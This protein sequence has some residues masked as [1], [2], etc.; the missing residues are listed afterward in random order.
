MAEKTNS[1]QNL[2]YQVAEIK[3]AMSDLQREIRGLSEEGVEVVKIFEKVGQAV[4]GNVAETERVTAE[5]Q[6]S[7]Q[8]IIDFIAQKEKEGT[9]D[10][11]LRSGQASALEALIGLENKLNRSKQGVLRT[12]SE[13]AKEENRKRKL[14]QQ[15]AEEKFNADQN[16][17]AAIQE[18]SAGEKEI[19]RILR[20]KAAQ[21]ADINEEVYKR[22]QAERDAVA[23]EKESAQLKKQSLKEQKEL[24]QFMLEQ[25]LRRQGEKYDEEERLEQ[26]AL[27]R[28]K[29]AIAEQARLEKQEALAA[30]ENAQKEKAADDK[31]NLAKIRNSKLSVNRRAKLENDYWTDLQSNYSEDSAEYKELEV[32][33]LAA[34]KKYERERASV[35]KK[36]RGS[37]IK[38]TKEEQKGFFSQFKDGL[39]SKG[40]G[41]S[42]GRLAGLGGIVQAARKIFQG[43][44]KA[45]VG[46]F[47]ASVDFE[48]QLAQLQAVTGINNK[49]LARLEKNVLSVAGSTKFTSEEIVQL[50]TELG[51]LGFSVSEIEAATLAVAR[52]AQALGEKVGP[53]AQRI[54]QILNQFNLAAAETSRVSD[55]LVSVINSSALSFEGFSTALQYI[56]PLGAEVGTTFEETSVAMALLADNGFTASRIGTGLRGILTE[57]SKTGKDLNTVI[58]DL[59]KEE[60]TLAEAVDL[61]GKRNAAQLIT[62]VRTAKA[63]QEV[64][65]S[66]SDLTNEYF[67]TGSA[68]IAASQQVDT[69]QGNLDLLKSAVN[70]VQIAF[71]NF[72]KTSK[73]LKLAL[74]FIDEEGYNAAL[75]AEAIASADPV[76]FSKGMQEA[77]EAV[78]E[79]KGNLAETADVEK[80]AAEQAAKLLK[81]AILEPQQAILD[82]AA[83]RLELLE[84]ERDNLVDVE[85]IKA[86]AAGD[87]DRVAKLEAKRSADNLTAEAKSGYALRDV[88]KFNIA[89]AE[90]GREINEKRLVIS[91]RI[92]KA[93]E[94]QI[95]AQKIINIATSDEVKAQE[96]ALALLIMEAG[97]NEALENE[98]KKVSQEREADLKRLQN[99]RDKDLDSLKKANDFNVDV[100]S[101]YA[102]VEAKIN[103]L[104][105]KQK[106][107]K[108]EGQELEG[109]EL[110]LFNAKL[111]QYKQE[112]NSLA[113]LIVQKGDLE[114]LAQK[115]FEKEFKQLANRITARKQEL[116]DKQALLDIE[117]K[118]QE[119][120]SKNARTEEERRE[121]TEALT[122]LNKERTQNEVDAFNELNDITDEYG[123]LIKTIGVEIGRAQ[124]DGRFI[125]KAEER[126]KSFRLSFKG[127]DLDFGDLAKQ[128]DGLAKGLANTYKDTLD[129]GLELSDSEKADVANKAAALAKSFLQQTT[130]VEFPEVF[131]PE[132]FDELKER[133]QAQLDSVL[134]PD[135]DKDR[136]EQIKKVLG[137]VL[138]ELADAAKEYNDTAL[139]NT[140]GR[141]DAELD[142]IK[143]RYK[144][145]ED[146][147]K[148]QLDNQLITESQFRVK[149]N[150]LKR[151]QIQE[152]NEINKKKFEA[153]KK[154]DL[155]NVAIDTAEAIA[156][157]LINNYGKTDTVT[158]TGLTLA[159]NA[160]LVAGGALKAD[161][162][163]RR[164]F[165][166]VTFEE[167]GVV[168]GPSHDQGGVPFSVQGQGGYEMEGGEFIINK[169]AAA[170]HR[171]LLER[172]N[173]S[174]KPNTSVSDHKFAMGG[175]VN[176]DNNTSINV[177]TD[178]RESVNYLKAIAEA[179]VS[180]AINSNKPLRA[181]VSQRDLR[182][183]ENERRLRERN[184]RI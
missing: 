128:I 77:A 179:S 15:A 73:L 90:V 3:S 153:E 150:E 70:R 29:Q 143:N 113:N 122:E 7:K 38:A 34:T 98:R 50:Q 46:S 180:T 64:G 174:V 127:L 88:N 108:A 76:L 134:I 105:D 111:D 175:L 146:I 57:L 86:K 131:L 20:E 43:L 117:I 178:N 152:E 137:A 44:K 4:K 59:A 133:I 149:S 17:K 24:E 129:N 68:A 55:S 80:V 1:T 26:E 177:K 156:S 142:A 138:K 81:N 101:E 164:K 39:F 141:L 12:L 135:P 83:A 71:G 157:N 154:A 163:R 27:E 10:D 161:A 158:A 62:L 61:V 103:G 21:T 49:E 147:L 56:G 104:L 97:L 94:E 75:S 30:I 54:G 123:T 91:A 139:Q 173:G 19:N 165:F 144:T 126:L 145:E 79:L 109:E 171:S 11:E 116:E 45:I 112:S 182:N 28:K 130:G 13:T 106:K 140:Q 41:K 18:Q 5:I 167:G 124:L 102:E 159:G 114:K 48:A 53:V 118:T 95:A 151:K 51:K 33:K 8:A 181:F 69:F 168:Q 176:N 119:N 16:A 84:K 96:K 35:V 183:S 65:R 166:P 58:E 23:R 120:L 99:L 25:S 2:K 32:K 110:L 85:I 47:K 42:L 40:L 136:K 63:Q 93:K 60:L 66:L 36:F 170:F 100:Q 92:T 31:L 22:Q 6:K 162:I 169:K 87:A 82:G 52:T 37:R 121:A 72:L 107:L 74:R 184:D 148:S 160:A 78:G 125:E 172:I 155:I 67:D 14:Q 9:I 115:E 89:A 132:Q